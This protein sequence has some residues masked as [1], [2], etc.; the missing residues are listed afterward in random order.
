M[1]F[2]VKYKPNSIEDVCINPKKIKDVRH[3]LFQEILLENRYKILILSGPSGSCKSS[4]VK[5]LVKEYYEENKNLFKRFGITSD[6]NDSSDYI[7]E[8]DPLNKDIS[9][10]DFLNSCKIFKKNTSFMKFVVIKHLPNIYHDQ[11]HADF[12]KCIIEWLDDDFDDLLPPLVLIISECD[13]P[14]S[15]SDNIIENN[16][17]F[18]KFDIYSHYIPE[19]IFSKDILMHPFVKRINTNK[20]AKLY[21]KKQLTKILAMEIKEQ[22]VNKKYE[23][24]ITKLSNL[25]D[26]PSALIQLQQYIQTPFLSSDSSAHKDTGL[27]MFHAMGKIIYGTKE[28]NTSNEDI[29]KK[30]RSDYQQCTESV[31]KMSLLENIDIGCDEIKTFADIADTLSSTDIMDDALGTEVYLRKIRRNMDAATTQK[32]SKVGLKFTPFFKVYKKKQHSMKQYKDFQLLDMAFTNNFKNLKDIIQS[33][34]FYDPVIK[35]L[36]YEK[37]KGWKEYM[38]SIGKSTLTYKELGSRIDPK[39]SYLNKL[40]GDYGSITSVKDIDMLDPGSAYFES[41]YLLFL[42][43]C[44][45]N[46]ETFISEEQ[47]NDELPYD[48]KKDDFDIEDSDSDSLV[49]GTSDDDELF[50]LTSQQINKF[51]K[52]TPTD[53][54][55]PEN[56]K[57]SASDYSDDSDDELFELTSQH[58]K[59]MNA[60]K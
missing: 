15:V 12:L 60:N 58:I 31:F 50:Q 9:F 37:F 59:R 22:K 13:L 24:I 42:K 26:L 46:V 10:R 30:L 29:I 32:K 16:Y 39:F 28:E 3:V 8:Y 19:T 34:G 40:G 44:Q 54:A 11:T 38:L 35:K 6:A 27:S 41:K 21:L 5:L 56:Q 4:M 25:G 1:L 17:S 49:S 14:K 43:N 36:H 52:T 55:V 45:K 33:F 51:S 57:N 20:I 18:N 53:Q 48:P 7:I 2:D 47:E 23:E